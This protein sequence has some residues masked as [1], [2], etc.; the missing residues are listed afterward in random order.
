ME[1]EV[2]KT[3]LKIGDV[4]TLTITI[5]DKATQESISGLLPLLF[6]FITSN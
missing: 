5:K 3:T 1:A 6:E 4:A 2:N